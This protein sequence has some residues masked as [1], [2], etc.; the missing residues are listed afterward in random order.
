MHCRVDYHY[1]ITTV[2]T[3]SQWLKL[4]LTNDYVPFVSNLSEKN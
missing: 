4:K 3:N 2:R 1:A